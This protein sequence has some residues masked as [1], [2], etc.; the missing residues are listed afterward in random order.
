MKTSMSCPACGAALKL[1]NRFQQVINCSYCGSTVNITTRAD[2]QAVTLN[3][4]VSRFRVGLK[5]SLYSR[6]FEVKAHVRFVYEE[7]AWDE[8]Y[9]VFSDGKIGW[10]QEDEGL[11]ILFSKQV[12]ESSILSAEDIQVGT[13]I[14]VNDQPFFVTEKIKAVIASVSGELPYKIYTGSACLCVDGNVAGKPYALEI[15]PDEISL[16]KGEII[17]LSAL[18]FFD[19]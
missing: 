12:L 19:E 17:N 15:Y 18:Q 11:L 4:T 1:E 7:G 5:A 9:L 14:E 13:I 2:D 10:L 8:Y 16:S 6:P 3:T